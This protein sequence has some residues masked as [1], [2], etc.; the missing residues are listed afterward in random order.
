[1]QGQGHLDVQAFL[2]ELG[3]GS[4]HWRVFAL[5]FLIVLLDGFDTA[6][7]GYIAP[8][9]MG[10]WGVR[11]A[12]LGPVLTVGLLGLSVGS[13]LAG[14]LADRFGRKRVLAA[15]VTL[16]GIA[17]LASVFA[18]D[19]AS[20]TLFRFITGWGLGAAMPN[21][22]TMMSEF[23]PRARRATLTNS[24][25]CGFPVGASIGGFLAAWMIP[26]WGWRSVFLV[27]GVAPL[28]LALAIVLLLPESVR[29]LAAHGAAPERIRA[30]LQRIA[31][32]PEGIASFGT[33]EAP[34]RIGMIDGLR[35]ILS[36]E[37]RIGTFALWTT[38]FMGLVIFYAVINWMPILLRESGLAPRTAMLVS[39][40]FPLGG[41]GTVVLS[42]FMDRRNP[43]LM[44]ALGYF[45]TALTLLAVGQSTGNL[46]LLVVLVGAAGVFMNTAQ[47]SMGAL[48][49]GF[50][51]TAGRASGVAWMTGVGRFGGIAGSL[52]V[53]QVALYG[54][55]LKWVF[56]LLALPGVIAAA[57]LLVKRAVRPPEP[58]QE[59]A[60]L[61]PIEV[62]I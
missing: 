33:S 3:V 59:N 9:L 49:A 62:R 56:S 60:S 45:L 24:M 54:I 32:L 23:S 50:Y 35:R 53:A 58:K 27:G 55:E 1:M 31:R 48:A 7:I 30:I 28:A 2:D 41:V 5:C 61:R 25:F 38:Y 44:V 11:K 52:L 42:V 20:L 4:F 37:H 14:P 36:R 39:A 13:L 10:E 15:S 18:Y 51:P 43:D 46:P 57:A 29:Y 21:A 16:F 22:V 12:D 40:L 26:Q 19:L 17:T 47:A 34:A 6:A 8:S